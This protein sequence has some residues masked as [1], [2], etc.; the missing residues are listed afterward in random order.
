MHPQTVTSHH[1]KPYQQSSLSRCFPF[2][3][4]LFDIYCKYFIIRATKSLAM[5]EKASKKG[6]ETELNFKRHIFW[7]KTRLITNFAI[8]Q[9]P[10]QRIKKSKTREDKE[11]PKK[12]DQW[13]GQQQQRMMKKKPIFKILSIYFNNDNSI[14]LFA[15]C[16]YASRIT[17]WD[18]HES[19]RRHHRERSKQKKT[20]EFLMIFHWI[21]YSLFVAS[22][23]LTLSLEQM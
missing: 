14:L 15:V 22:T 13:M 20:E 2:I 11:F 5:S 21:K 12:P 19:C 18:T 7:H 1:T 17:H 8:Q 4:Q 6:I 23:K 3:V 16:C 9:S 10:V